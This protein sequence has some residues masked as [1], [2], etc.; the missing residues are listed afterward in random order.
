MKMYKQKTITKI[1][2]IADIN[3]NSLFFLIIPT[4]RKEI[5]LTKKIS[6][7]D[8]MPIIYPHFI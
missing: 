2:D 1:T 7:K 3:I 5:L 8:D 4:S 6:N